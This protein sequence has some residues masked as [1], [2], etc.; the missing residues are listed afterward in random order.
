MKGLLI[1]LTLF[2]G[3][4]TLMEGQ[5]Y[6]YQ[7]FKDR[8]VINTQSVETLP[9]RKLDVRIMH[10]FGDLAGRNGGEPTFFGLELAE[11]VAIGA[12]YGLTDNITLGFFRAKGAGGVPRGPSGLRQLWN[13]IGKYRILRQSD[14]GLMPF[15]LTVVG[16]T[17]FSS[18]QKVELQPDQDPAIIQNFPEFNH[19]FAYNVQ[20]LL[21][22]KFS[23]GF[24]L[25]LIPAY[26]HRNLVAFNDQNGI[27][28]M[29]VATRVQIS[30]V[31]GIVADATFPFSDLRTTDNDFYPAIGI[32]LEIE[33][34]GHVFQVNFTNATGIMETD[35][36]PYTTSNWLEGQYR[37]GFTISRT[38]NL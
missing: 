32:G 26:T 21:A 5:N 20:L 6:T 28:S 7:T 18:A 19:R 33:T 1:T 23:P 31:F 38:F 10:R 17:T 3:A 25:Q 2:M 8:R 27:F 36:I 4:L 16:M 15:T 29:G 13:L 14:D 34:G 9:K 24:S 11:D 12:E 35:F 37:L 30:K 22:R